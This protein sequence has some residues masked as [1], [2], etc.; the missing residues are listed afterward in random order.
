[1]ALL[2]MFQQRRREGFFE[3]LPESRI[4]QSFN[5]E[6]FAELIGYRTLLRHG[7]VITICSQRT[8]MA[9]TITTTS[10]WGSMARM[11]GRR[12][13]RVNSRTP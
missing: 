6:L 3:A 7:G 4:E 12:W 11:P 1:M 5:E 8:F 13:S 9:V 2:C 10:R